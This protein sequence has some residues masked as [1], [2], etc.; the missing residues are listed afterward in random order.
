MAMACGHPPVVPNTDDV[1]SGVMR[2]TLLAP[3]FAVY[4]LPAVSST[5]PSGRDP[6]V[7]NT[8]DTPAYECGAWAV[9]STNLGSVIRI[10]HMGDTEVGHLEAMLA[11]LEPLLP[12]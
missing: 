5:M 9:D 11:E 6:V 2:V 1:P 10:G 7:P 8:L 12:G 4:T 3:S